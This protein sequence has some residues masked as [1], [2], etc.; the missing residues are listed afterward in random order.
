MDGERRGKASYMRGLWSELWVSMWLFCKGYRVLERRYKT[1]VGEIDLILK[2]RRVIVFCEVKARASLEEGLYALRPQ[3]QE[4][5][6]RAASFFCARH[7]QFARFD[8]R[9]DYVVVYKGVCHHVKNAWQ[10]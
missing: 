9:F 4:R 5:I 8:F 10:I 7:P 2:S 3:Q 1:P 6:A